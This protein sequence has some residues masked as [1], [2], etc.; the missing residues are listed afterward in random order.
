MQTLEGCIEGG[1]TN[2]GK[3]VATGGGGR[4]R[5]LSLSLC[6]LWQLHVSGGMTFE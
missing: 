6:G 3:E 1:C 4:G 2:G 5:A